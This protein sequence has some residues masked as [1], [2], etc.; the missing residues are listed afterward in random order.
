MSKFRIGGV[1]GGALLIA[2]IGCGSALVKSCKTDSE[3]GKYTVQNK[4]NVMVQTM[5]DELI[6]R[7][8]SMTPQSV[9]PKALFNVFKK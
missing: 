6:L 8:P 5:A 2:N 4:I 1:L 9:F 7:S 3:L